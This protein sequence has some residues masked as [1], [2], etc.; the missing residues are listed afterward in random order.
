M[1]C[2]SMLDLFE[3][4]FNFKY[5]RKINKLI[6]SFVGLKKEKRIGIGLQYTSPFQPPLIVAG[7]LN[8][9]GRR[10]KSLFHH[11]NQAHNIC[12]SL[13]TVHLQQILVMIKI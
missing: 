11:E 9:T 1:K 6:N 10:G 12:P 13:T 4:G 3:K 2:I 7:Q 5:K 8:L